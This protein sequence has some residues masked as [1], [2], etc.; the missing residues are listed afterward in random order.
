MIPGDP[1]E[2]RVV[3]VLCTVPEGSARE[4]VD[5]LLDQRLIACAQLVGPVCSRYRW[6]GAIEEAREILLVLKTR[7]SCAGALREAIARA[8][9]YRVPEV[10]ELPVSGG[11]DAYLAWVGAETRAT[12][13]GDL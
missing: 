11:L 6:Q 10:L 9:P 12:G 3:V 1:G 7:A 8:H 13:A 2:P 4:L 5:L